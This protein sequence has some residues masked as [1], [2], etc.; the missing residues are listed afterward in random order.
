M[1]ER[2]GNKNMERLNIIAIILLPATLI[3]GLFGMNYGR[4]SDYVIK[5]FG[6]QFAIVTGVIAIVVIYFM[7]R[8]L[9]K[10]K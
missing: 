4:E 3:A 2:D 9:I 8:S 5:S 10:K 7:I 6:G 1:E